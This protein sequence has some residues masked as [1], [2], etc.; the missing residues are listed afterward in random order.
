V[1]RPRLLD[2]FREADGASVDHLV[3]LSRLEARGLA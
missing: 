1:N 3:E 2:L